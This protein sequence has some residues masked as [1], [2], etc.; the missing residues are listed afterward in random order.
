MYC[1]DIFVYLLSFFFSLPGAAYY[2]ALH[3]FLNRHYSATFRLLEACHVDTDFTPEEQS[4][5][6]QFE[7][8][9]SDKHPDAHACRLKLSLCVLYSDNKVSWKV[10]EEM[11]AY[12]DSLSHVSADCSLS[13]DEER[14]VLAN[15]QR[16]AAI[17]SNRLVAIERRLQPGKDHGKLTAPPAR[18]PGQPWLKLASLSREYLE[19][20][21]QPTTRLQYDPP[22]ANGK[23][24]D[25]G[26]L[27]L[28]LEDKI[29]AGEENGPKGFLFFYELLRGDFKVSLLGN[30][31]TKSFGEIIVRYMQLKCARW[32]RE[33]IQ[34]GEREY[35][36]SWQM[37]ELGLMIE[38]PGVWP[39]IP[40][41]Q[42]TRELLMI[43]VNLHR[44]NA[45][46]RSPLKTA[47]LE[48]LEA[49]TRLLMGTEVYHGRMTRLTSDLRATKQYADSLAVAGDAASQNEMEV[50]SVERERPRITNSSRASYAL[51]PQAYLTIPAPNTA[52][53]A[54]SSTAT[55]CDDIP[56][57]SLEDLM[58]F[59]AQPLSVI[60]LH[61]FVAVD[62]DEALCANELP[63]DVSHHPVAQSLV[64]KDMLARVD[65]DVKRYADQMRH[66]SVP[67]IIGLSEADIEALALHPNLA[68]GVLLLLD[69]LIASLEAL[70]QKV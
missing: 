15:C 41:D 4:V 57:L 34:E 1:F 56:S 19:A 49:Q 44:W 18:L 26:L 54:S 62:A 45:R 64:A 42:Q 5:F 23:L 13:R 55:Q 10:N 61:Q 38:H 29:I 66:Q 11:A 7:H 63:F 60:G 67:Y 28:M 53:T 22:G 40:K 17:L 51:S 6:D 8:A 70:C 36:G 59:A 48:I 35:E 31:V 32:G 12:L 2:M 39:E 68:G 37:V 47:F 46:D 52:T 30:D 9:A 33:A 65:K 43:G 69:N 58:A 21:G 3:R 50:E 14:N 20:H 27:E 16:G 25:G 24:E